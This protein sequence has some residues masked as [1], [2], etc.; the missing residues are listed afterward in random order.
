MKREGGGGGGGGKAERGLKRD[1]DKYVEEAYKLSF[2]I[3]GNM[4]LLINTTA[5]VSRTCKNS[6]KIDVDE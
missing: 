2:N 1:E 5:Q 3:I 4:S 6:N